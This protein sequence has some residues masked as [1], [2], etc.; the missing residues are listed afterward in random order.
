MLMLKLTNKH[1][2]LVK[3]AQD[4]YD[5]DAMIVLS[6]VKGHILSGFGGALKKPSNGMCFK[7]R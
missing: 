6:H 2:K 5:S 3:I 7:K 1:L 4:I